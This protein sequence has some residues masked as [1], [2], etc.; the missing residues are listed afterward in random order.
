MTEG[1]LQDAGTLIADCRTT[2]KLT[3]SQL[4]QTAQ[5]D[6]SRVSRIEKGEVA[7]SAEVRRLLEALA[8]A[9]ASDAADYL[10]FSR[11]AWSKLDK[12][13]F[14]NPQR[15]SIELA[16]EIIVQVDEFLDGDVQWPLRRQ[17]ER[18]REGIR[19]AAAYLQ[20]TAH[21]V[22]FIGDIGV[23][24]STAISA[25]FALLGPASTL[26]G[27][28]LQRVVLETGG[29]RVTICEVHLRPGPEHGIYV[30]PMS[31]PELRAAVSDFCADMWLK[32]RPE[33]G[34]QDKDAAVSVPEEISRAIRNMAKIPIRR[35]ERAP[36]GGRKANNDLAAELLKQCASEEEFRTRVLDRIDAVKRTRSEIWFEP[37][38]GKSPLEWMAKTFKEIN[39]GRIGDVPLPRRI[40][41]LVPGFGQEASPLHVTVV[42]TKG[43]DD[44]AIR[45]DL[46]A[47]LTDPRTAVVL[48]SKF[49]DAPGTTA[50][51]L[52]KH[53]RESL[54]ERI[55]GGRVLILALPRAG[56]A[57]KVKDDS[58]IPAEDEADGYEMKRDQILRSLGKD[59]LG[60]APILFFNAGSDGPEKIRGALL[61]KISDMRQAYAARILDLGATVDGLLGN[62]Q[63]AATAAA[64]EEVARQLGNFL[65]AHPKLGAR[66]RLAHAEVLSQIGKVRASSLWASMRRDGSYNGFDVYHHLGV[67]ASTDAL[68]RSRNWFSSLL[69]NVKTMKA[70]ESLQLASRVLDQI[71]TSIQEWRTALAD[72]ARTAGGEVYREPLQEADGLWANCAREWGRGSGFKQRVAARLSAWFEAEAALKARLDEILMARFAATVV[73]KLETLSDEKASDSAESTMAPNVIPFRERVAAGV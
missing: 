4:A 45:P 8:A 10:A 38:P 53:M 66:E 55:E 54:A 37:G 19:N 25:I 60:G 40:D 63:A 24:K 3:Q 59:S 36:D 15:T 2:L 32:H 20:N 64:I 9:G 16:D 28:P 27:D 21:H 52:L 7:P 73:C 68:L 70:D 51:I 58:G 57:V 35:G 17:L 5:V 47:R 43:V 46:D 65:T 11:R 14:R 41:L 69:A 39:N 62:Q 31:D 44:I 33:E 67:G 72:A 56:E 34:Q 22:A 49:N 23:G 18:Q 13:A 71:E 61:Q 48:C 50:Q 30:Q 29:G 12:P 42:D 1:N 26:D 6:Q